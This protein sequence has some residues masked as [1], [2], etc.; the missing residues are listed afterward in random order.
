MKAALATLNLYGPMR[1]DLPEGASALR[2]AKGRALLAYLALHRDQWVARRTLAALLWPA[3]EESRALTNLRQV[4]APLQRVLGQDGAAL[5]LRAERERLQLASHDGLFIDACLLTAPLPVLADADA[6]EALAARLPPAGQPFLADLCLP[7]CP[8]FEAWRAEVAA[9]LR[10][11][12]RALLRLLHDAQLA[13]GQMDEALVSARQA[14][15]LDPRDE[16]SAARLMQRLLHSGDRRGAEQ[17]LAQTDQLLVRELGHRAS[18]ELRRLLD[19]ERPTASAAAA[20]PPSAS[21]WERRHL[22]LLWLHW[23][24]CPDTDEAWHGWADELDA[25]R[26]LMQRW[27]ARCLGAADAGLLAVFG[28]RAEGEA[29]EW[30][31]LLAAQDLLESSPASRAPASVSPPA[32]ALDCGSERLRFQAG[33]WQLMSR[34]PDSLRQLALAAA[35]GELLLGATAVER[36]ADRVCSEPRVVDGH[37]GVRRWQGLR[38]LD[39]AALPARAC[40]GR[41]RPLQELRQHWLA[42]CRGEPAWVVLR[43][44]AGIG[45]TT[46]AASFARSLEG[47]SALRL[48]WTCRL[49]WQH[50]PL[51]PLRESLQDL[52]PAAQALLP[53]RLQQL[54]QG[55]VVPGPALFDACFAWLDR[56]SARQPVLLWVDDLHWADQATR[57]LLARYAAWMDRQRLLILVSSRPEMALE[58]AGA[59]PVCLDVPPLATPDAQRLLETLDGQGRLGVARREAILAAAAGIPLLI[60]SMVNS[61][62]EGRPTPGGGIVALMQAELDRLGARKP[63]LQAAALIGPCFEPLLLQDL[64]GPEVPRAAVDQA[65]QQALEC[66]VVV[67]DD[68]RSRTGEAPLRFRHALLHEAAAQGALPAQLRQWHARLAALRAQRGDGPGVL[69]RHLAG[70]G[71]W[72]QACR[73]WWAAGQ[74]AL[75]EEFAADAKDS[76]EQAWQL[77]EAGGLP[78]APSRWRLGLDRVRALQMHEGYGSSE[79]HRLCRE[80]LAASAPMDD[81]APAPPGGR[82]RFVALSRLYMGAGSQGESGGLRVA[83]ELAQEARTDAE[84]LTA[85]F[86]LG[87]SLFWRGRFM[88][89][90]QHQ[91]EGLALLPHLSAEERRQ[92]LGDDAGVL[93]LAFHGWTLWFCGDGPGADAAVEQG[94]GLARREGRNHALCFMLTFAAAMNWTRGRPQ[95][96]LRHAGEALALATRLGF[97]LWQGMNGLFLSWARVRTGHVELAAQVIQ[98]AEQAD[99]AY[100]AGRSTARWI[101]ASTL[102]LLRQH[103]LALKLL[104]QALPEALTDEDHY[105]RPGL[106]MLLSDCERR[107][108]DWGR[109]QVL[110]SE[111][112]ALAREQGSMGWLARHA[113]ALAQEL[114][115]EQ[116]LRPA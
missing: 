47:S 75:R 23:P 57:E 2:Y 16:A 98:A 109:A 14:L 91:R 88:E 90:R 73:A 43:G 20:P 84:R 95:A 72:Q 40:L 79:A 7:E 26:A 81:D 114:A 27:G 93:L 104:H 82:L 4:L 35:P 49:E 52:P 3:L 53:A 13:A 25:A 65:L 29:P 102:E 32:L 54:L 85:C 94:L 10:D 78:D 12:H 5:G 9:S 92:H 106:L 89:A 83:R 51:A 96:V 97:P 76:L 99:R 61:E 30:R 36:L 105:C 28:L 77:A 11:R 18:P 112:C 64:L 69:A 59:D 87:N 34:R 45:K 100:K 15:A 68:E 48:S 74:Q 70:A 19:A 6:R 71:Q 107:A 22:A 67:P 42:A 24:P 50:Q 80:L 38:G 103:E 37:P 21:R 111:A 41:E 113:P 116:R 31:A 108:G 17:V 66:R 110:A 60:E 55:Q 56:L 46:L 62:L 1:L 86:A 58:S 39:P 63:V 44:E 101:L 115:R 8:D 33:H